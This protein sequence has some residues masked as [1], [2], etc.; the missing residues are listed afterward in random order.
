MGERIFVVEDDENIREII[1]LALVSNGYEV[2]QFDNAID[3]L[4]EI[5]KKAPSLAI[6]DLMLPKMSGIDA[7]KEI[8]E[9]DSELPILI[10]SAKDRE[11]DK[12]NG[13]DSGSDD[14]M[15][16]RLGFLNCKLAF[17]HY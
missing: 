3:A 8:R 7:I 1:N 16:N 15:T 9:T 11:I 4:A 10:L 13:L 12:V 5:D 6:F 14:Y 2:V 17:A